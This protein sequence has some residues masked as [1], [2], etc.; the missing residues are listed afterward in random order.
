MKLL[1]SANPVHDLLLAGIE[2]MTRRAYLY[3]Q[4]FFGCPNGKSVAARTCY[5]GFLKIL[6]VYIFLLNKNSISQEFLKRNLD[7]SVFLD[8]ILRVHNAIK[9]GVQ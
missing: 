6:W 2:R 9:T 3:L 1:N 8:I 4:S 7:K 5:L